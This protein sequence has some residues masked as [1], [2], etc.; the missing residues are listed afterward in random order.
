MWLK[1]NSILKILILLVL[2]FLI[3]LFISKKESDLEL[4]AVKYGDS[5]YH[6]RYIY[7]DDVLSK[8]LPFAWMFYVIKCEQKIILVDTGFRKES[9]IESYN[10]DYKNPLVLLERIGVKPF[11]V[12]DVI[13]TH[14][15][16]DHIGNVDK[17][18]NA[19]IYIQKDELKDFIQHSK[20]QE[21]VGFL[22]NN[23]NVIAFNE[24]HELYELFKIEKIGGHTIGSSVVSFNHKG[25]QYILTGDECYLAE[26]CEGKAIGTYYDIE[27]NKDFIDRISKIIN[28]IILTFHDPALFNEYQKIEDSILKVI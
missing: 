22:E 5:L 20:N 12:T 27:K 18:P 13:I 6:S 15:H 2:L 10:I 16:F 9:F 19:K 8:S 14:T 24:S 21:I 23:R 26:N 28:K 17:F 25:K 11:Q 1:T 7:Y 4:Y 3:I